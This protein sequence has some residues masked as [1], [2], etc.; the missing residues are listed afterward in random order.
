MLTFDAERHEYSFD[1]R[2][3]PSVTKILAPL[4]D[5][6]GVPRETLET[7]A[8]FGRNVHEACDLWDRGRLDE[9]AL[10]PGLLPHVRGWQK[11]IRDSGAVVI[12]SERRVYHRTHRYAGTL[13]R[14]LLWKGQHR[15]VDIKTTTQ[16]PAYVGPQTAGYRAALLEEELACA[17]TRYCV[18]LRPND[19]RLHVLDERTD[20]DV[21]VSCL[22]LWRWREK[23]APRLNSQ[24]D[25]TDAAA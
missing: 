24:G 17:A 20:L 9:A 18:Q 19:Y 1:G 22:N 4:E 7:A 3:V 2:R 6:S 21:F 15:L 23:H 16:L 25:S 10:D 8:E 12:A 5:F 13:D 14:V 11:F